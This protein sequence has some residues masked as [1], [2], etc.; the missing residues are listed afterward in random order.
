MMGTDGSRPAP[1]SNAF[2]GAGAVCF[3]VLGIL[4]LALI[5][6]TG[7]HGVAVEITV[8]KLR[9]P[10]AF[11]ALGLLLGGVRFLR[12]GRRVAGAASLAL[13]VLSLALIG[14][15]ENWRQGLLANRK[16][17]A[18]R[19]ERERRLD[20]RRLR[21]I[22]AARIE[23]TFGEKDLHRVRVRG[24][25][26][27]AALLDRQA[28]EPVLAGP[29]AEQLAAQSER[30]RVDAD[31]SHRTALRI[32]ASGWLR[33]RVE[34]REGSVLRLGL[35][36]TNL[37]A[38]AA[39]ESTAEVE[40]SCLP[41]AGGVGRDSVVTAAEG[42][43]EDVEIALPAGTDEV[44]IRRI[45]GAPAGDVWASNPWVTTSGR[46]PGRLVLL[47]VI[48]A[49]RAD[50][51]ST[52]GYARH[53]TGTMDALA[54]QGM[55]FER[56]YAPASWTRASVGTFLTGTYPITHGA[57]ARGNRLS[58]RV[59]SLAEHLAE[60]GLVTAG[61]I[62][63]GNISGRLGFARGFSEYVDLF[64]VEG[65]RR[66]PGRTDLKGVIPWAED[67]TDYV[68]PWL[69]RHSG[70]DLFVYVHTLDPHDPYAPPPAYRDVDAGYKGPM[71]GSRRA[72]QAA[73]KAGYKIKPRDVQ[74]LRALY[75]AEVRYADDELGRFVEQLQRLGLW[76]RM[77]LIVTADHGEEFM[78]H[79]NVHHGSSLFDEQ[80]RV[81]L[82]VVGPGRLP[83]GRRV[84]DVASGVDLAPT[85]C[86]FLGVPRPE[87]LP[88]RSL[89]PTG[90]PQR[91]P[92]RPV[93]AHLALDG[94]HLSS[95]RTP[96]LKLVWDE[97]LHRGALYQS[98]VDPTER[99]PV[100]GKGGKRSAGR[101]RSLL[102]AWRAA[103]EVKATTEESAAPAL[104]PETVKQLEALGYLG[105]KR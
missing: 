29:L 62:A 1:R 26:S 44:A 27:S 11:L 18:L 50:A 16:G 38:G 94:R 35:V 87:A 72:W 31:G 93:F 57:V 20:R 9:N 96:D 30:A 43:W 102:R 99:S 42:R 24:F 81:P 19:S 71:D 60:A 105:G 86:D 33:G 76:E 14:P 34:A 3:C 82:I 79:G 103:H 85:V 84:F 92:A 5:L 39:R 68:I 73:R 22:G 52:Y 100:E 88:G 91:L 69:E 97:N 59:W 78:E 4:G 101:L 58:P 95:V 98:K 36:M 90:E 48:D 70:Q 55:L 67:V 89:L 46:K 54:A 12:E 74:H 13:T 66:R 28:D 41:A 2:L 77:L 47:Y 7:G 49:L 21:T 17:A 63:N 53:T 45:D 64:R 6:L 32:P 51:L 61:F 10:M 25:D 40:I 65:I 23:Q 83:A 56:F 15:A 104:D 75:D 37:P 8:R 80:I